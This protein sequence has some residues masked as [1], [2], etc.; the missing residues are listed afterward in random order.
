MPPLM[1]PADSDW[2]SSDD[3]SNSE[4][5]G[6]L[7]DDPRQPTQVQTH[8]MFGAAAVDA[9]SMSVWA[10]GSPNFVPAKLKPAQGTNDTPDIEHFC[11]PIVHPKTG[12]VITKYAKLANNPD[13]ELRE[14]W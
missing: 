5:E 3:E 1:C 9:V 12:E 6:S 11:S 13:P 4:A 14:T 7:Q 10:D 2:D 8:R